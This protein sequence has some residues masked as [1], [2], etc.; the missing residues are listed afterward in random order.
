M[1]DLHRVSPLKA[2]VVTP[3]SL[4]LNHCLLYIP[5]SQLDQQS[6]GGQFQILP[7]RTLVGCHYTDSAGNMDSPYSRFRLIDMLSAGSGSPQSFITDFI[8]GCLSAFGQQEGLH[9]DKPI[10][11]S[12]MN[13]VRATGNP[14]HGSLPL[15]HQCIA[16]CTFKC[17]DYRQQCTVGRTGIF[18]HYFHLQYPALNLFKYSH[19]H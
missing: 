1:N 6:L 3:V 2:V 10:F 19:P 7:M 15:F 12:V 14:Q 9:T 17:N 4:C 11:A 5:S 16:T 8:F 13:P 18:Y